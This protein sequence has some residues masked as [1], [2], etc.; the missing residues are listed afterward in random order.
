MKKM[1]E[2]FKVGKKLSVSFT[3]V[4]C[5]FV[6]ALIVSAGFLFKVSSNLTNFYNVSYQNR[7]AI[8]E[9]RR[10]MQSASK[11]MLWAV[12][13]MDEAGIK[14]KAEEAKGDLASLQERA[15]FLEQNFDNAELMKNLLAATGAV[16]GKAE[17]AIELVTENKNE[18]A[19]MLFNGELGAAIKEV[20]IAGDAIADYTNEKAEKDY[21]SS[22]LMRNL[23]IIITIILS[24]VSILTAV[25]LATLLSKIFMVPIKELNL[26][27]SKLSKGELEI[28]IKYT[29][30]DELGELA[31][32]FRE[33]C[34]ALKTI[35]SDLNLVLTELAHQNLNVRSKCQERYVGS[36]A[37]LL[38][39]LR[40]TFGALNGIM[41][42]INLSSEQVYMGS[43]QMAQNAQGLAEGATEQASAIEELQATITDISMQIENNAKEVFSVDKRTQQVGEEAQNSN[44]EMGAM[45]TAMERIQGTSKEIEAIIVEIEDIASQ[46][47]LLSLNAAIEAARAGEAGKGFAVVADQ[48]RKLADESAQSA[49]TTKKLIETSMK[50]VES[51]NEIAHK[52]AASLE[53]VIA[54]VQEIKDSINII[55]AASESQAEAAKQ[56]VVG[57]EQISGVVQSNSAAAE[58]S[59]ATSEELSAQA[60]NLGNLVSQF[61][62]MSK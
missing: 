23:A 33:T 5:I 12:A 61:K 39:N 6:V 10:N 62:L 20:Q 37:P 11:N 16:Q 31:D 44:R 2:N 59:S 28:D 13:T 18:E 36:F 38:A 34:D 1:F 9:L 24:A 60:E 35:I 14:E 3:I 7:V 25:Y 53:N 51:G 57:V 26:A 41:E 45:T 50:E 52:T 54:G 47:N 55:N 56:V 22:M 48:I 42:D 8:I 21:A 19:M 15:A 40:Q 43:T 46:T 58:E 4:I 32:G 27:S 30:K 17:S 29:S 49:V